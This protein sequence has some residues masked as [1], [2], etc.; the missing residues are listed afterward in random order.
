MPAFDH[1]A[2]MRKR[3]RSNKEMRKRDNDKVRAY[4]KTK[5]GRASLK[6]GNLNTRAKTNGYI[7]KVTKED[8]LAIWSDYRCVLCGE[9]ESLVIDHR[10]ALSMGGTN[11]I[12]NL[13]LMCNS[14]HLQK[15][16]CERR[17]SSDLNDSNIPEWFW[18]MIEEEPP[19]IVRQ[20]LSLF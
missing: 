17:L 19:A 13:Q 2:Y 8:I 16:A 12:D 18:Q 6:A 9:N 3:R 10:K 4:Q 14:C 5:V 11:T 7:G 15:S 20:Q 1:A